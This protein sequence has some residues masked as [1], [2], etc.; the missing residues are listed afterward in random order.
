MEMSQ[1]CSLHGLKKQPSADSINTKDR[2]AQQTGQ[3][4]RALNTHG[5]MSTTSA[6]STILAGI[7]VL[8]WRG[9]RVA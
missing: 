2:R 4:A 5:A 8:P 3:N 6:L 7:G 1:F 9:L